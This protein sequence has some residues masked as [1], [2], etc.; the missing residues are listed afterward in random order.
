MTEK[1]AHATGTDDQTPKKKKKPPEVSPYLFP[2]LLAAFGLWCFYDGWLT[3]NPEMQ[4]HAL[5]NRVVSF[6]LLPWAVYDFIKQKRYERKIAA[7]KGK[8]REPATKDPTSPS[9]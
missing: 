7:A 4:E 3:T 1:N 6:I 8:T 5:F 9:S 2:F